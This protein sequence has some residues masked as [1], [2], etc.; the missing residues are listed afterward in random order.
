PVAP[1]HWSAG[2]E[3]EHGLDGAPVLGVPG[4]RVVPENA[5]RGPAATHAPPAAARQPSVPGRLQTPA[6][7]ARVDRDPRAPADFVRPV[8][9]GSGTVRAEPPVRRSPHQAAHAPARAAG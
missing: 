9:L 6:A 2:R 1:W 3:F 5:A 4:P 8:R 7:A